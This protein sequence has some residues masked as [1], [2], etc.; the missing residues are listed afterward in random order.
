MFNWSLWSFSIRFVY[1][2]I[3]SLHYILHLF[4]GFF[5]SFCVSADIVTLYLINQSEGKSHSENRYSNCDAFV[6]VLKN[7]GPSMERNFQC[8]R[9]SFA[10]LLRYSLKPSASYP[11]LFSTVPYIKHFH[12]VKISH[13]LLLCCIFSIAPSSW[14][15]WR[16]IASNVPC[17]YFF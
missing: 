8:A 14:E 5:N 16:R 7:L 3:T 13:H 9:F 6:V 15:W 17:R 4:V 10:N 12:V 1:F 11:L 2:N